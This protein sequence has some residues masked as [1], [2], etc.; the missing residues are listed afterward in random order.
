MKI[1]INHIV[2]LLQSYPERFF[3]FLF[4]I[5]IAGNG[6]IIPLGRDWTLPQIM[7]MAMIFFWGLKL[8]IGSSKPKI[9]VLPFPF[10]VLLLWLILIVI[11][12]INSPPEPY[13][14]FH[15]EFL[16][17]YRVVGIMFY[18]WIILDIIIMW[19]IYNTL[20]DGKLLTK[21][22]R[23]LIYSSF[24]YSLY[25]IYQY[26]MASIFG[27]SSN[28]IV[29]ALNYHYLYHDYIV[30]LLSLSREPLYFVNFISPVLII[31]IALLI[32]RSV[33]V[34]RISKKTLLIIT[35]INL[36]AFFLA[37][38][39]GGFVAMAGSFMIILLI[40][41]K[42]YAANLSFK[43]ILYG[44]TGLLIF[45]LSF[46][47]LFG[48]EVERRIIRLTDPTSGYTRIVS[49]IEGLES[50]I[51]NPYFGF[52]LGHSY[53]FISKTQ[54]HNAYLNIMAETGVFSFIC[55]FS[56][57]IF[58]AYQLYSAYRK[59]GIY[60]GLVLG[61][62]GAFSYILIQWLSFFAYIVL[63]AWF[64]FGVIMALPESVKSLQKKKF[65]LKLSDEL[66]PNQ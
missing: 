24:F 52:G 30:R 4:V 29:Y 40:Y 47:Q 5:F 41:Y 3:Y 25:G 49:I 12:I 54:I 51:Q 56:L 28:P 9:K 46:Y 31:S 39:T 13:S 36:C 7:A 42:D 19:F 48:R 1:K 27:I 50:V 37:K 60:K 61:I 2:R 8:I 59:A 10:F 33:N 15:K 21:T 6:I 32:T 26:I 18:F 34:L 38:S 22:F 44:I 11:S 16:Q 63:F 62:A 58:L 66:K 65:R 14:P 64:L 53:F 23:L 17:S 55:F 43:K 35:G 45:T 57:L 20:R